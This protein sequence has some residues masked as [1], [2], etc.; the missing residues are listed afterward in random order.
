MEKR[1]DTMRRY[2][3]RIR[4]SAM[5]GDYRKRVAEII[6]TQAT[7]RTDKSINLSVSLRFVP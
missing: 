7:K 4:Q 1:E 3:E 6:A 2:L 5:N